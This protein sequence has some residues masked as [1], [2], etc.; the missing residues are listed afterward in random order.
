MIL[1]DFFASLADDSEV[2]PPKSCGRH[3]GRPSL[4][5]KQL[6]RPK[7]TINACPA[8]RRWTKNSPFC[9]LPFAG[10]HFYYRIY[11]LSLATTS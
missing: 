2:V 4:E 7:H 11:E 6:H 5:R 9:F 1:S 10:E 8:H 3:G